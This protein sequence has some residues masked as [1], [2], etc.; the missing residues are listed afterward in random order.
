MND[1]F[2]HT[3]ITHTD[4][5]KRV[6]TQCIEIIGNLK[7][8]EYDYHF[9]ESYSTPATTQQGPAATPPTE[10]VWWLNLDCHSKTTEKQDDLPS[11]PLSLMVFI[12]SWMHNAVA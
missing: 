3:C 11:H 10:S 8:V 6:F 4:V 12:L 7:R 2:I 1:T 9:L 5:A